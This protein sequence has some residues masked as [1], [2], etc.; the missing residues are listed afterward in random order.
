MTHNR[1]NPK[2]PL[3]IVISMVMH[4]VIFLTGQSTQFMPISDQSARGTRSLQV[5]IMP[6]NVSNTS[7]TARVKVQQNPTAINP[8]IELKS[9]KSMSAV[10]QVMPKSSYDFT[11]THIT[12]I[13][14][15]P[16]P[17]SAQQQPIKTDTSSARS[18]NP[19]MLTASDRARVVNRRLHREYAE[20]FN[21]PRL[22]QRNGWQGIVK[23]GLRISPDGQLS[24]VRVVSTSG[25]PI[26]DQNALQ[27]M[28]RIVKLDGIENWLDGQ[29][30]DT[31]V[32]IK[33]QLLGG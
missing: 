27:T 26:L 10:N 6:G 28:E 3:F 14:S 12:T 19:A 25:F 33:Y 31:V 5:L 13:I 29:Y 18:A 24:R 1:I 17:P 23:L 2:L 16:Q 4:G 20:Y 32:P 15:T 22:A 11:A 9:A 8:F 7:P 21:Y 30:F